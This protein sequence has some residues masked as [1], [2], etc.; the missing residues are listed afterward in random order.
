M[1]IKN[2]ELADRNRQ[3]NAKSAAGRTP[4]SVM[5]LT[6]SFSL[7]QFLSEILYIKDLLIRSLSISTFPAQKQLKEKRQDV[8]I[9]PNECTDIFYNFGTVITLYK[10]GFQTNIRRYV[11][12]TS[13]KL[14]HVSEKSKK[15]IKIIS[16]D[17]IGDSGM[18]FGEMRSKIRHRL[19]DIRLTAG[20]T[21]EKTQPDILRHHTMKSNGTEKNSLR[22]RDLNP[23]FQLYV[24]MLYPLSHTGYNFDADRN[25]I[26]RA[27]FRIVLKSCVNCEMFVIGCNNC[28]WLK[29]NDFNNN[30]GQGDVCSTTN[31]K[32][33][34]SELSFFRKIQEG[35]PRDASKVTTRFEMG[36]DIIMGT[37]LVRKIKFLGHIMEKEDSAIEKKCLQFLRDKNFKSNWLED[38]K[39]KNWLLLVLIPFVL[40][41][42]G[43]IICCY[44]CLFYVVYE[45]FC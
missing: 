20:E 15:P 13:S 38:L 5:I 45:Y 7:I 32:K 37:I 33:K 21:S 35:I 42:V 31:S 41:P 16:V 1:F 6:E 2:V 23:G 19:P 12:S 25:G 18:V 40:Y 24:L 26:D 9:S 27:V 43:S 34:R 11:N 4:L 22:R 8:I 17:G 29:Y 30:M 3:V 28:K 10:S 36:V 39:N 44:V 14:H